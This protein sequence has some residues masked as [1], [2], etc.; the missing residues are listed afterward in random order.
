MSNWTTSQAEPLVIVPRPLKEV[1]GFDHLLVCADWPRN[2]KGQ[3]P[4]KQS[5]IFI[6]LLACVLGPI[7]GHCSQSDLYVANEWWSQV[8]PSWTRWVLA[9]RDAGVGSS[10]S[11][12]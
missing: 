3:P 1:D 12:T 5:A 9:L 2:K 7:D 11:R 10:G 6:P 4:P 8:M